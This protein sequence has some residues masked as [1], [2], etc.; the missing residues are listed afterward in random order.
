MLDSTACWCQ[1]KHFQLVCVLFCQ[2]KQRQRLLRSTNFWMDFVLHLNSEEMRFGTIWPSAQMIP[3]VT[4]SKIHMLLPTVAGDASVKVHT[5]H[6]TKL[7]RTSKNWQSAILFFITLMSILTWNVIVK[8]AGK[9]P[10][11]KTRHRIFQ[12]RHP[13]PIYSTCDKFCGDISLTIDW[14]GSVFIINQLLKFKYLLWNNIWIWMQ[15]PVIVIIV[16]KTMKQRL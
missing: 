9:L 1:M 6:R 11:F 2:G 10:T 8:H 3:V 13:K 7:F 5:I 14:D 4:D 12:L 15:C 16:S